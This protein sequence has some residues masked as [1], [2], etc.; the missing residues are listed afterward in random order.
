MRIS[1]SHGLQQSASVNAGVD[2][3]AA[4]GVLLYENLVH[5]KR[6]VRR[7][8]MGQLYEKLK[9]AIGYKDSWNILN[10]GIG[11]GWFTTILLEHILR[12]DTAG[13]SEV[14][15]VGIDTS[16]SMLR[17][18]LRSISDID[19]GAVNINPEEA[20][21]AF[22][23]SEGDGKSPSKEIDFA[24][25]EPGRACKISV[26]LVNRNFLEYELDRESLKFD[27]CLIFFLFHHLGEA[28]REGV[29]RVT[30][31]VREDDGVVVL[32][33]MGGDHACWS[34]SFEDV[35]D[36]PHLLANKQRNK[37]LKFVKE[38]L[39]LLREEYGAERPS[40]DVS[41]AD[42][43][44]VVE[45]LQ[46]AGF[47]HDGRRPA[48]SEKYDRYIK[49]ETW[50]QA[51]GLRE[52][53]QRSFSVFPALSE[54]RKRELEDQL[55]AIAQGLDFAPN[56]QVT[57]KDR[58]NLHVLQRKTAMTDSIEFFSQLRDPA[59]DADQRFD[60][61]EEDLG[62]LIKHDVVSS[63]EVLFLLHW[64]LVEENSYRE[65]PVFLKEEGNQFRR[66]QLYYWLTGKF[67]DDFRMTNFL[68]R[69]LPVNAK[70]IT[71]A[72]PGARLSAELSGARTITLNIP[73]HRDGNGLIDSSFVSDF[74]ELD[75]ETCMEVEKRRK[76]D[77]FYLP[78]FD[79]ANNA[80]IQKAIE[81]LN[82]GLP[83]KITGASG[84]FNLSG[85]AYENLKGDLESVFE[86]LSSNSRYPNW[87]EGVQ[88]PEYNAF[89]KV[90]ALNALVIAES[91]DI[92][93]TRHYPSTDSLEPV[94]VEPSSYRELATGGVIVHCSEDTE[95]DDEQL[96]V[97][98]NLRNRAS[99]IE[100][101]KRRATIK[102]REQARRSAVSTVMARNMSHNFGSHVLARLTSSADLRTHSEGDQDDA[103]KPVALLNSY[104]RTRMDF[105]ADVA[106]G[107]PAVTMSKRLYR[108]TCAYFDNDEGI[109]SQEVLLDKISG[110]NLG[111]G[112]ITLEVRSGDEKISRGNLEEDP[113]V[114]FP[115]DMLGAHAFY[116][117]LENI[118]RNCA[119][120]GDLGQD[121]NLAIT[122]EVEE[123]ADNEEYF[124]VRI[125]DNIEK[126]GIESI[127]N[128]LNDGISDSI[129]TDGELRQG[130]WGVL[131]MKIAAA[132]LRQIDPAQ[133]DDDHAPPLLQAF[134]REG[135]QGLGYKL[136]LKRHRLALVLD[137]DE[138]QPLESRGSDDLKK[139]GVEVE[140]G[141]ARL[142][143]EASIEEHDFL[144]LVRPTADD[145]ECV[146]KNAEALP[147]RILICDSQPNSSIYGE[148]CFAQVEQSELESKL[149]SGNA[150]EIS[151]WLWERWTES[152][153]N[154]QPY[155]TLKKGSQDHQFTICEGGG[156]GTFLFDLHG[157][158]D[159][160][161]H[162]KGDSD[163]SARQEADYYEPYGSRTPTGNI[164]ANTLD[165]GSFQERQLCAQLRTSSE[166]EV[167]VVD[168]RVQEAAMNQSDDH[169]D[170][171]VDRVLEMMG[172]YVPPAPSEEN[173][174]NP[175]ESVSGNEAIDLNKKTFDEETCD[176]I[177]GWIDE[178]LKSGVRCLVIHLG[179]I[180]R[181]YGTK[182]DEIKNWIKKVENKHDLKRDCRRSIVVTSGRGTPS[183][184]P[185]ETRFLNYSLVARYLF[186]K[187][188]KYHIWKLLSSARRNSN[189]KDQ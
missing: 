171:N 65:V 186:E 143:D 166:F 76:D 183:N 169:I 25:T 137:F 101:H 4:R 43:E 56:S 131:E 61:W 124:C 47:R 113:L 20:T 177:E 54:S 10:A 59:R 107:A 152:V 146:A 134:A 182:E 28:W 77:G 70:L 170:E 149:K 188:S 125:F 99:S 75:K 66:L 180:E 89:I 163:A 80:K 159:A 110:T 120:H 98:L 184:L 167:A 73:I 176:R 116:L 100:Q 142:D 64:D 130:Y 117:I 37:Y 6:E 8:V 60:H 133:I 16:R 26:E 140:E 126:E 93:E 95:V 154:D 53:F 38:C 108:D 106:T 158:F 136:Y 123:D 156:T 74:M 148:D 18:L 96:R 179:I 71:R 112:S 23:E 114:A 32:S 185:D 105:L 153:F 63:P 83:E 1:Q 139:K 104:L 44:P 178:K 91:D 121:D 189:K 41:A 51:G 48:I 11:G 147:Q 103:L 86:N 187:R 155:P 175:G 128:D 17:H 5:G 12:D 144:V 88:L 172:V 181:I 57:V 109:D 46:E 111:G 69:R 81:D 173:E 21:Q 33:E 35:Y 161:T 84:I 45:I 157:E 39:T 30:D 145:L 132:Y 22:K 162:Q 58:L 102:E 94:E 122:V 3:H 7:E 82:R 72:D 2:T 29:S 85:E 127:A 118:I 150:A 19:D 67:T 52:G 62:K 90:S 164:L 135:N 129:L 42:V 151:C 15:L 14:K 115:S 119:K 87:H 141:E 24:V 160:S 36:I 27:V 165:W 138:N 97:L 9:A 34:S 40:K 174:S 78:S 50:L 92:E 13:P 68:F 79:R 31:L 49:A 168:E 55:Q